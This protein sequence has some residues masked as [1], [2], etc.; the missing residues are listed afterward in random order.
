MARQI[1]EVWTETPG[2]AAEEL[3]CKIKDRVELKRLTARVKRVLHE[4]TAWP[5]LAAVSQV[6]PSSRD[7][8]GA[9]A[10]KPA[11]AGAGRARREAFDATG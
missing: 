2:I 6:P 8:G 11:A 3:A 4:V 9:E 7:N 1:R 5:E 10:I